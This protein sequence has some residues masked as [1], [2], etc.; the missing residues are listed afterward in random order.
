[1][2]II[3]FYNFYIFLT[4]PQ[5]KLIWWC[6]LKSSRR[7]LVL[8][9]L[10]FLIITWSK[11]SFFQNILALPQVLSQLVQVCFEFKLKGLIDDMY[12]VTSVTPLL[13]VTFY[14]GQCILWNINKLL[15]KFSLFK[16]NAI[17]HQL[18]KFI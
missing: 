5:S 1:M 13:F 16:F 2:F 12:L 14:Q 4:Y 11:T 8:T 6:R 3:S 17:L 7:P 18:R 9:Y 15:F 10:R